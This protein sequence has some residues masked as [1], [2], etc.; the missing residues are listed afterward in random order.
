ME[1]KHKFLTDKFLNKTIRILVVVFLTLGILLLASQFGYIWQKII[2][3]IS[4]AIIPIALAWL[5]SLLM[6]PLIQLLEHR[7]V[8]PRGL[9]V[10]VV[11]AVS[12][13]LFFLVIVYL[14]PY[15]YNQLE[16]F[17]ANDLK[18]IIDYFENDIQTEIPLPQE[19]WDW[20]IQN[21]NESQFFESFLSSFATTMVASFSNTL[22]NI[23]SIFVVLPVLL[24]YYLKDYELIN[25]S[26]RSIIP[27][28]YEK[29]TSELGSKLNNTVGAYIR[30]QLILMLAIGAVATV[31]YR[32]IDLQYFFIFGLIVGLTNIIPY[33]GAIIAMVPVVIY[34]VITND[35]GPSPVVVVLV[36]VGLQMIEGNVFQ[37][38]IMGRQLEIHPIIIITSI[39]FFGTLFGAVGVVFA[40]PIAAVIRVLINF[41][42]EKKKERE[43]KELSLGNSP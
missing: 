19:V 4:R 26:I 36:N 29:T 15:I 21:I 38:I 1:G 18:A 24:F 39:M 6:Y 37:P 41:Y 14:V 16:V 20:I 28:K 33:F 42:K 5:I 23:I 43:E 9:S 7:G 35:V 40:A 30:G 12:V 27:A 2:S 17:L 34:A 32:L 31:I 22:I 10:G 8:G 25:D 11:Y 3:A 13:S